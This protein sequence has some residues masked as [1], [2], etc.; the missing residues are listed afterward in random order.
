MGTALPFLGFGHT[1]KVLTLLG[2]WTTLQHD[3]NKYRFLFYLCYGYSQDQNNETS[4]VMISRGSL[5]SF[6]LW[7]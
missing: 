5:G 6:Q 4:T 3:R 1:D 2:N 7:L